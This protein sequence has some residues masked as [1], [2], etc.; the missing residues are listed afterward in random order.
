MTATAMEGAMAM[1]GATVT[2]TTTAEMDGNGHGRRDGDGWRDSDSN[3]NGGGGQG[4]EEKD[5]FFWRD[6]PVGVMSLVTMACWDGLADLVGRRLGSTNGSS[7]GVNPRRG[8]RRSLP[9][10]SLHWLV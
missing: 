5:C 6:S 10:P 1:D 4:G 3:C 8:V 9:D 7:I 2:A